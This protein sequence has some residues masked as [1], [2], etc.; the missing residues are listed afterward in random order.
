MIGRRQVLF[1]Q[2]GGA[3]THDE[4]D[5]KLADSLRRELRDANEIRYPRTPVED[6]PSYAAWG[7]AI[8]EA[9]ATLED[10]AVVVGHSVGGTLLIATGRLHGVRGQAVGRSTAT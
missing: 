8:S 1:I 10:G 7:P 4:W 9:I 6:D 5:D 2:G 3:G